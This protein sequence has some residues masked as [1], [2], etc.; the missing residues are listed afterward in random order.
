MPSLVMTLIGADRPGLV[1]S[2]A[3]TVTEHGA[4]WL[5]SRMARLAGQFAG[6]LR[7][8]VPE[9]RA[10]GLVQALQQLD[11][12]GLKVIVQKDVGDVGPES[13]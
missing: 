9:N 11:R 4:N 10:D 3:A 5:E 13:A 6:I 2:V 7:V 8:D 1:R 12:Q